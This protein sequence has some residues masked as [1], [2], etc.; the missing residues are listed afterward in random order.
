MKI[1][2]CLSPCVK[3]NFKR[4]KVLKI[5]LL[6]LK[7][8]EKKVGSKFEHMCTGDHFLNITPKAETLRSIINKWD[9]LKP[10]SFSK[11]K[12]TDEMAAY[13]MGKDLQ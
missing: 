6:T 11:A 9:F 13:R 1:D 5:K 7:L 8:K 2:P 10:K 3:L 12:D 4:I